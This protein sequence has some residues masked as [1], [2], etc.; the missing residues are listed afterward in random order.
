LEPGNLVGFIEGTFGTS[1]Q[2]ALCRNTATPKILCLGPFWY[3]WYP[4]VPLSAVGYPRAPQV[5]AGTHCA[6]AW[7]R[8]QFGRCSGQRPQVTVHSPD[9]THG[10]CVRV[11]P[12]PVQF[13]PAAL[14]PFKVRFNEPHGIPMEVSKSDARKVA[15]P[16]APAH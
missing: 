12:H 15:V 6:C 11:Q 13:A 2:S 9:S 4:R 14:D 8:R 5:P 7:L 1:G 16:S 3:P 10:G